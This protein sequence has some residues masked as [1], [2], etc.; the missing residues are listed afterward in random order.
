PATRTRIVVSAVVT[1]WSVGG[2]VQ[3]SRDGIACAKPRFSLPWASIS[4]ASLRNGMIWI[5]QVGVE[6]P[7]LTVPL[8]HPNAALIPNLFAALTS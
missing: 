3:V 7:V 2:S 6:K 8:S 5:H 4:P 1:T